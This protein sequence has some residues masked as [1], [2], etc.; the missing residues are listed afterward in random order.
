MT[1]VA[2]VDPLEVEARQALEEMER[3]IGQHYPDLLAPVKASL[4]AVMSGSFGDNTQ[5]IAQVLVGP[6]GAGKSRVL[7]LVMPVKPSPQAIAGSVYEQFYHSDNFT[8]AS[9]VSHKADAADDWLNKIDLLPKIKDKVLVTPE[10]API[11]HGRKEE[12]AERFARLTRI[13]DGEGYVSDSGAHG[14]RGYDYE[15]NFRWLGASTPPTSEVIAMMAALGPRILFYEV[16]RPR[17]S[18]DELVELLS[19]VPDSLARRE[20]RNAVTR[21]LGLLLERW[22]VGSLK[23]ADIAIPE[24]YGRQLVLWAKVMVLLRNAAN[25]SGQNPQEG[26]QHLASGIA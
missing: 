9:F 3:V 19:R 8:P 4:A 6:S 17:K 24:E 23:L 7:D 15:I 14:R 10:L 1:T 21:Y 5:P 22:P 2:V 20:C 13:L 18:N 25:G 26:E 11:F 12:L 16:N